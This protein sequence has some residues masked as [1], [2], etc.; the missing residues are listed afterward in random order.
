MKHP[1]NKAMKHPGNKAMKHPGNKA[2]KHPGNKAMKHP[3]N[4]AMKHPGNKAMKHPGNK[5]LCVQLPFCSF[6]RPLQTPTAAPVDTHKLVIAIATGTKYWICI[7]LYTD[8][9]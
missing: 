9:V 3:G 7:H 5:Y 2:M 6:Q 8:M 4:K 1:G